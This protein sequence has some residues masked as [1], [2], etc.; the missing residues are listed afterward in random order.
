MKPGS[1]LS[2]FDGRGQEY[3]AVLV[4]ISA[5]RALAE[6]IDRKSAPERPARITLIQALPKGQKM[7][8][9]FR[10]R[11][12]WASMKFFLFL[13]S[14]RFPD[15]LL[16]KRALKRSDG[17]KSRARRQGSAAVPMCRTYRKFSL[18]QAY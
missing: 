18:L 9:S 10:R 7:D 4:D 3:T 11:R 13:Q 15:C 6:I 12:N 16:K 14:A 5:E 17:A 1:R 8:S 2:L